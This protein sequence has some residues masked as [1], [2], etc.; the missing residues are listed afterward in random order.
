M[1]GNELWTMTALRKNVVCPDLSHDFWGP[2]S[3]LHLAELAAAD[4]CRNHGN[5]DTVC[6]SA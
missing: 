4:P 6:H 3:R 5:E 1:T 2:F